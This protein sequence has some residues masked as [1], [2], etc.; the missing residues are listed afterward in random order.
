MS[1][2]FRNIRLAMAAA[3]LWA[4]TL[5]ANAQYREAV[6]GVQAGYTS[7]NV[8]ATAGIFYQYRLSKA[9]RIAPELGCVFRNQNEDAFIANFNLHFPISLR[10]PD[11]Q[12]Y[13]LV[14]LAFSSWT[15]HNVN[16]VDSD[17]VS[18]RTTK[19]GANIGA[20]FQF[21]TSPSLKLKLEAK[22]VAISVH[23]AFSI[24]AGI[25]YCF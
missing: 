4:V 9:L 11:T 5:P 18:T 24:S 1:P 13:P 6:F 25:G 23:S 19:M 2:I 8:S 22:Y 16:M 17:D 20:G 14:G 15:L 3:M 10:N 12:I 21:K 7:T